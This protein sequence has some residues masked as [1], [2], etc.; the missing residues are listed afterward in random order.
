[1]FLKKMCLIVFIFTLENHWTPSDYLRK[2]EKLTWTDDRG[3]V[4]DRG[5]AT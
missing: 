5:K 2:L 4:G 3:C 1:M